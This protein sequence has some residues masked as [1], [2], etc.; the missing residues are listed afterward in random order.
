MCNININNEEEPACFL[1]EKPFEVIQRQEV[2]AGLL[3][4]RQ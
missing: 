2:A 4:L 1:K 3:L